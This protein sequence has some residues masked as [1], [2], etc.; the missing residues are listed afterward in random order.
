MS[1]LKHL[2]TAQHV[3][4]IIQIIFRELVGSLL[5]SL[6]YNYQWPN[7]ATIHDT[8]PRNGNIRRRHIDNDSGPIPLSCPHNGSKNTPHHREMVQKTQ[9]GDL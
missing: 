9:T 6:E 2:K 3:S 1:V 4:I 5:K 7:H 8:K